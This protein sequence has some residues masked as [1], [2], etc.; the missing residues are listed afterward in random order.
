MDNGSVLYHK[1][2]I[3]LKLCPTHQVSIH[4]SADHEASLLTDIASQDVVKLHCILLHN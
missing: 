2:D 4:R 3:V 1:C